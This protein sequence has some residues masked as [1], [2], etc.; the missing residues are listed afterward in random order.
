MEVHHP[1]PLLRLTAITIR[2]FCA[3]DNQSGRVRFPI[4]T[5]TGLRRPARGA[6]S[7]RG[8]LNSS[9]RVRRQKNGKRA[10]AEKHATVC[11]ETPRTASYVGFEPSFN[12]EEP[13]KRSYARNNS[14]AISRA[15]FDKQ[16]RRHQGRVTP[17]TPIPWRGSSVRRSRESSRLRSAIKMIQTRQK[18]ALKRPEIAT[19]YRESALQRRKEA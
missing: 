10:I 9:R 6:M 14:A 8:G 12:E 19:E 18:S 16:E 7:S 4:T 1:L 5:L 3:V 11:Q 15:A 13:T 2:L 17:K